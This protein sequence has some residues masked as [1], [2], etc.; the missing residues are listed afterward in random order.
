MRGYKTNLVF[1]ASGNAF[2]CERA[3]F[4]GRKNQPSNTFKHTH[5]LMCGV[6][7]FILF[8]SPLRVR[9]I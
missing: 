4:R 5:G 1:V 9:S 6:Q 2:F 7:H 3:S 8:D